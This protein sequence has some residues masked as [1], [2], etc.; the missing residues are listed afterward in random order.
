MFQKRQ[1]VDA[2]QGHANIHE[3]VPINQ[4]W[5]L[6]NNSVASL[7][8]PHQMVYGSTQNGHSAI[9][10]QSEHQRASTN[11]GEA[12]NVTN[13]P[14]YAPA[15]SY[16]QPSQQEYTGHPTYPSTGS[17]GY[18]SS[19]YQNQYCGYQPPANDPSHQH[20][21]AGPNTGAP[22]QSLSSFQNEIPYVGPTSYSDTY[23]N[24]GD[25]QTS[26]Y[27]TSAYQSNNYNNQSTSWNGGIGGNVPPYEYSNYTSTEA[28]H[29]HNMPTT[30][31]N[32][33]HY[34]Q[35]YG[36]WAGYYGQ[37]TSSNVLCAPGTEKL[38]VINTKNLGN[39]TLNTSSGHLYANNQPPPPGTSSWR[40]DFTPS[41]LP[42]SQ[43]QNFLSDLYS[44]NVDMILFTKNKD[45]IIFLPVDIVMGHFCKE[46]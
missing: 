20:V 40:Q 2:N 15:T 6:T 19:E 14:L 11:P 21:G 16:V 43:V 33:L 45:Q 10:Y 41:A 13:N 38:P 35:Q 32:P 9:D 5:P 31:G 42:A 28:T 37:S 46:I 23:Y 29:A 12:P 7:Q 27:Q 3:F 4:S 26:N 25:Y 22:Y 17:Y 1:A 34:K 24:H 30:A 36:Q 39:Q 18:G 44:L 8:N